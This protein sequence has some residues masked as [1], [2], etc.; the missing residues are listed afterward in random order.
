MGWFPG[1]RRLSVGS[2]ARLAG[3]LDGHPRAVE[4]ANDLVEHALDAWEERKG[5]DWALPA[6]PTDDDLNR[7]WAEIVETLLPQVAEK[8]RDDP[9]KDRGP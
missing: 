4:F 5:R 8:L 7:E 1:L 3:R 6:E 9:W 2:R